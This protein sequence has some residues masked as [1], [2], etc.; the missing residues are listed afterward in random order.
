MTERRIVMFNQVSADGYF[1]DAQGDLDWVVSDPEIQAR[2]VAGMP[3][4]DAMLFGRHTYQRFAA[5]WPQALKDLKKAGPHGED[6]ADAGFAAMANWLN[7][8]KKLVFS[9]TLRQAAW[10]NSELVPEFDAR[11]VRALKRQPGKDIILFGSGSLVTQLSEQ[12]LIDEYRFVVC[13]VLL[14]SGSSVI[15]GADLQLALKLVRAESFRSGNVM[16][17]YTPAATG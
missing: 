14:G 7:D 1:S 5:F 9:R 15:S 10:N 16:L 4:S 3:D 2:A 8:T 12:H 13:P 11:A 6:K 17:T